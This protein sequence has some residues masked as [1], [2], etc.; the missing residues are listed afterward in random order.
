MKVDKVA[1]TPKELFEI[2]KAMMK[3]K[4]AATVEE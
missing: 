3:R 2:R 4:P 1:K